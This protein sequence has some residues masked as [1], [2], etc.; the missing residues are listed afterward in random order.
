MAKNKLSFAVEPENNRRLADLLGQMNENA[1]LLEKHFNI[2]VSNR[3][4]VF[5]LKGEKVDIQNAERMIHDLYKETKKAGNLTGE[6]VSII[7]QTTGNSPK[8]TK[9]QHIKAGKLIIEARSANQAT[10]LQDIL[11]YDL[12]FSI[13]PAGTGKTFLAVACAIAAL[14]QEKISQLI[15]VRP[16][17]EAGEQLGFLPGDVSQKVDP[18][19]RPIYDA[20]YAM[21]GFQRVQKMLERNIIELA[22]LAYMRGRTLNDAFIILDEAQNTT[23]EQMKMFL[24]RI[25]FNSTTVVTGDITQVDLPREK[26]SGLVH[27][28]EL[29]KGMNGIAFS[30]FNTEDVV[31]HPLVKKIV[32]AYEAD[33]EKRSKVTRR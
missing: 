8:T 21:L 26:L 1:N 33:A 30:E 6:K 5:T 31:R 20:L 19:L 13:G 14:E 11:N 28:Y 24:T 18:F 15:L 25:G 16:V 4:N 29:L 27:A 32:T 7:L 2:E 3:G 10:Y 9:K 22:P 17:I 23:K 12:T